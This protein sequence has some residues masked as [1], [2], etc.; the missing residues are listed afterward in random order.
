MNLPKDNEGMTTDGEGK[1]FGGDTD[2][3]KRYT[4][5]W[6]AILSG[7]LVSRVPDACMKTQPIIVDCSFFSTTSDA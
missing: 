4:I 1:D 7:Q 5:N 2:R 6:N 3:G